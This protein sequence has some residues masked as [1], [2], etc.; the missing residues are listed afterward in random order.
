MANIILEFL[1]NGKDCRV[2]QTYKWHNWTVCAGTIVNGA[3]IPRILWPILG[4]PFVGAHR[5]AAVLHDA[6]YFKHSGHTRKE[7]DEMFYDKMRAD[8]VWYIKAKLMYYGVR[9]GGR[10][11]WGL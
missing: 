2:V 6:Y 10:K 7:V 1:D 3:S 11:A 8:G 9:V 5:D 4:S